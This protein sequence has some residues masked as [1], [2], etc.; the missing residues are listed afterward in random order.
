MLLCQDQ[1]C[2]RRA[3]RMATFALGTGSVRLPCCDHHGELPAEDLPEAEAARRYNEANA[4]WL[5]DYDRPGIH[6]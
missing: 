5:N 6:L 4:Y 2:L 1:R 3:T